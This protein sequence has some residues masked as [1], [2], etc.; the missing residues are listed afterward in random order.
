MHIKKSNSKGF[1]LIE[2]LIVIIIIGILAAIAFVAYSGSQNKAHKADAE[3][4]LSQVK[5][6]LGEYNADN[7]SY[8][9]TITDVDSWLKSSN[10]GNNET[11]AGKF[12]NANNYKYATKGEAD[13]GDAVDSTTGAVTAGT[14]ACSGFTLT[15]E[16]AIFNGDADIVVGN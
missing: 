11:L 6:K 3:S 16:K 9:K 5:T 7:S 15:A 12:T 2:L 14:S 8:P 13:C 10:G 4:T 1:T